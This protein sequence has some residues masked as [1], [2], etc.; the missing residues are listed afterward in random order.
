MKFSVIVPVHNPDPDQLRHCLACIC[1]QLNLAHSECFLIDDWSDDPS[2]CRDAAA[3]F[4]GVQL[5]RTWRDLGGCAATNFGFALAS[6]E[7]IHVC[8]SDDFVLQG[9]YGAILQVA[10]RVPGAALYATDHLEC[11]H[12][13]RPYSAP[14]IDWLEGGKFLPVHRGNPLA[15]AATVVRRSFYKA[16]GGW[17]DRLYHC[18]DWLWFHK[19]ATL[20]GAC[21]IA[22]PLAAFR[23]HPTSHT[24]RLKRDASNLRNYVTMA[25]VASSYSEVDWPRFRAYVAMRARAQAAEFARIGDAEAAAANEAFAKEVEAA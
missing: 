25:E 13:G 4:S 2:V 6:G 23:H 3:A 7:L 19:A 5:R 11:D 14:S 24:S 22:H 12:L 21:R 8:H 15:V 17:D 9:F 10:E 20:G 18:A 1:G 16:H